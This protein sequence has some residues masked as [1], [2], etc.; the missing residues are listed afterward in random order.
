MKVGKL[1]R[2]DR[3][4]NMKTSISQM[5]HLHIENTGEIPDSVYVNP[6]QRDG[7]DQVQIFNGDVKVSVFPDNQIL[8]N[9]FWIGR[10]ESEEITVYSREVESVE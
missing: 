1:Y 2:V 3:V 4:N 5:I 9:H 7:M 10:E 8:K 6:F